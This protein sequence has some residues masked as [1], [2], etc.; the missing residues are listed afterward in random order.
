M[1]V[2]G[3]IAAV[4]GFLVVVAAFVLERPAEDEPRTASRRGLPRPADIRSLRFPTSRW[5]GYDHRAVDA[6][7][8]ALADR[9]EALYL[10]AG[11]SV[12]A[13]A[14]RRLAGEPPEGPELDTVVTDEPLGSPDVS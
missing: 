8:A 11:P 10:A 1:W 5:G 2:I 6:E 13:E 12:L 9:Y 14:E 3:S 4:V 7:L